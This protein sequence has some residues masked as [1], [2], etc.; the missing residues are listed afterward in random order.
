MEDVIDTALA[1]WRDRFPGTDF[2]ALELSGRIA[3]AQRIM[4]AQNSEV[5]AAHD[6][7]LWEWDVLSVLWRGDDCELTMGALGAQTFITAG[8]VTNRVGRLERRGLVERR[9]DPS[10]RR[11]VLVSLTPAGRD[12]TEAVA[13]S[14]AQAAQAASEQLVGLDLTRL[15]QDLAVLTEIM[16]HHVPSAHP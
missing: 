11:R 5:L 9:Q 16:A 6:L 3:L 8:S 2:V 12:T 10:S 13:P 1:G 7:E 14:V 15:N 4:A